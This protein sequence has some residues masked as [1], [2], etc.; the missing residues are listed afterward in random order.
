MLPRRS[1]SLV[2]SASGL[3]TPLL[4]KLK[5]LNPLQLIDTCHDLCKSLHD[6]SPTDQPVKHA[7][8]L[9]PHLLT[10]A[11]SFSC[12]Y[13][14]ADVNRKEAKIQSALSEKFYVKLQSGATGP[15]RREDPVAIEGLQL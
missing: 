4:L 6:N 2:S 10:H 11:C 14:T 13:G 3:L 7:Q 15:L 9:T 1:E 5:A 12:R 8:T